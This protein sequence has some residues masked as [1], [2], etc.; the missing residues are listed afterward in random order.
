MG[1]IVVVDVVSLMSPSIAIRKARSVRGTYPRRIYRPDG[2]QGVQ[3]I[4][5]V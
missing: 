3:L 4:Y 2:D 1:G 5:S